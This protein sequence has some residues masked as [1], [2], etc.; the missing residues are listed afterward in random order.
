MLVDPNRQKKYPP[1]SRRRIYQLSSFAGTRTPRD[2]RQLLDAFHNRKH[3][4]A[5]VHFMSEKVDEGPVILQKRFKVDSF[6]TISDWTKERSHRG[7][8]PRS[9]TR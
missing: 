4:G 9:S 2:I 5:T 8:S 6:D 7:K 3:A 1:Y